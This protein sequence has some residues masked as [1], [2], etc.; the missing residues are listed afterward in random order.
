VGR[1]GAPIIGTATEGGVLLL[2]QP[3]FRVGDRF[4]IQFP[5]G[6]SLVRDWGRIDRVNDNL[7]VVRPLTARVLEGRIAT[8]LPQPGETIY[9]ALRDKRDEPDMTP[10]RRWREG[11]HGDWIVVPGRDPDRISE[12]YRG[13][14]LYVK[15]NDRWQIVGVLSGLLAEDEGDP[16]GETAIGYIG[17]LEMSR[18]LPNHVLY[19]EHDIKPL[20][21]D[22]EFGVPLQPGDIDLDEKQQSG[23]GGRSR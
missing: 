14:G 8:E 4:E 9:L 19:F 13:T 21:P 23:Q 12:Q 17:L 1:S 22:F 18:I 7:A 2:S 11:A 3:E 20:R 5:I 6:N 15:R 10:V 16:R